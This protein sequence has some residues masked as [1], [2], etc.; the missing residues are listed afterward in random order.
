MII[1][2]YRDLLAGQ[3]IASDDGYNT[4]VALSFYYNRTQLP[5]GIRDN[6]WHFLSLTV[7]FPSITLL[8]DGVQYQ[9]TRG[10][11]RDNFQSTVN[12]NQVAGV[13]YTMPAQILTKSVSQINDIVARIGGSIRGSNFALFGEMRQLT[14]SNIVDDDTF[15]CL[16]SCNNIIGVDPNSSF[17]D[18]VTFY[19][20][21]TRTFDFTGPSDATGYT[22]L[23]QSLIYYTNGFLLPEESGER[24]IIT[25]RIN[26]ERGLGNEAELNL[27]GRSNQQDPL[28]DANGDL[29]AGINFL[30]DLREDVIEDQELE[31]LSPRSFIVDGD[32]DSVI[33]SLTVNLT[34]AQNGDLETIRLLDNPPSLVSVTNGNG[35]QLVA[36]SSSKVI[37]IESVDPLI[38]TANVFITTLVSLRY[39]NTAEE[40]LDIDRIIEFTVFDSL[41]TNNPRAQT[42]IS[43]LITDDVPLVD[44]NGP[45]GGVNNEIG[46]VESSPP[47]LLTSDMLITD[48]DSLELTQAIARIDRVFDEGNETLAFDPE[49]LATGLM[50]SPASCNGTEVT[51]TGPASQPS[52]QRILRT[53]QYVNLKQLTDLP[54]LRD[55]TVF[56][57]VNDGVNSSDPQV[58]ILIDFIPLN[59]RVIL[60]LD[61]PNQNYSITFVEAQASPI[62]C[63]SLVR[64][65]DSSIDTIESIVVSIRDVLPDGVVEN[66]ES[67]SLTSI[68]GLDNVI[69]IEINTALKRITFSQIAQVSQYIEAVR[70]IQYYNGED[71]PFL[72]N[73]FVD[74]LVIPG[75]GAPS[76][77]AICNITIDSVN[78]N[79]PQCPA[80]DPIEISEN[81]TNDY[82]IV[83]LEATDLDRGEDGA[84]SY[85][86]LNGNSA[87][88][89]VTT[90]GLVLLS[91]NFPLD[92][93]TAPQHS[94]TVEACDNGSPRQ[95]CQFNLTI[96]VTDVN[97][98]PPVF[99][100]PM[101]S[102]SIRENESA[103][104]PAIVDVSD[105]DEGINSQL[106]RVEIDNF[107]VRTGCIDQFVIRL[108]LGTIV[109]STISPGLDFE[110]VRECSFQVI[111]YDA[112]VPTLSGQ[113]AVTVVIIDQDDVPPVFTQDSYTFTV[114]EE[115]VAPTIVGTVHAVDSDSP[116]L[117]YSLS[118]VTNQ[119]EVN[120]TGVISI[121]F[122]S[123]RD[124][125]T[126]YIFTATVRDPPG[127]TDTA[128]V[129]V[130]VMPINNDA[131]QLDLN[132]TDPNSQDAL[133]PFIFIE[134]GEAVRILTDPN[135]TD[136]DELALTI[137][138]ITV[139]VA[140]SGNPSTE[141]LSILANQAT[142]PHTVVSTAPGRLVIQP[143]NINSFPDIRLL[144]QSV[145]YENTED[146]ISECQ[147]NMDAVCVFGPLSRTL[148]FT[149]SDGEFTSN[150]SNA[151]IEFQL[152]NDP[153]L[154]DLDGGTTGQNFNTQF[155]EQSDGVS[156]VNSI[157]YSITDEDSQNLISLVC[158]LTN[159]LDLDDD[160]LTLSGTLPAGLTATGTSHVLEI[161]GNSLI[162]DFQTAL[163]LVRYRSDSN[164][165]NTIERW[166]QV[167]VTDNEMLRSNI[168]M[169]TISFITSNDPPRLDLDTTSTDDGFSAIYIENGNPVS[170]SAS[171]DVTDVDNTNLQNLTVVIT[172][173]SG[174][175]DVLSLDQSLVSSNGLTYSYTY[176]ELIVTGTGSLLIYESIIE[177]IRYNNTE[178]EIADVMSRVVAFTIADAD[179]GVSDPVIAT[180][181]IQPVDDNSPI[182]VPTNFNFTILE[183]SSQS[184]LVGIVT[185]TDQDLPPG[186]ETPVFSI[187][188]STPFSDFII[189]SDP[190]NLFQG[191]ILLNGP[192]DYDMRAPAY[193]LE[194]LAQ[195]GS[196]NASASVTINVINLPDI[197]PMFQDSQCPSMFFT[198]ENEA[199]STPLTPESC[200]ATDPDSLDEIRYSIEGNVFNGI[201]VITIDQPTGRLTVFDDIDREM[202]GTQFPVVITATDS[203]QSTSQNVIIVIQGENE[204]DPQFSQLVYTMN[205][206]ENA[207]PSDEPIL[208]VL[209]TDADETPDFMFDPEF[210]TRITYS[211]INDSTI[212]QY[213]SINSTSGEIAQLL[214]IDYEDFQDFQFTV[215]ANDNDLSPIPREL[216]A[217]VVISVIN[218]NDER[219][220]FVNLTDRIFV[221][222]STEILEQFGTIMASDPDINA[223]LRFSFLPPV[224]PQFLLTSVRGVLS[225]I[226]SLDAEVSPREFEVTIQVQDIETDPRYSDASIAV[227]N[228]T[229]IVQDTNDEVPR[230]LS[231]QYSATVIENSPAGM[232]VLRVSAMDND[233]G[234]DPD[235]NSNGNNRLTYTFDG[236]DSPPANTFAIDDQTGDITIVEP[237]NR[238]DA[239]RY[240]F[241]VIVQDNPMTG[242]DVHTDR[243]TVTIEIGDVNEFPPIAD[244]D[245]YFS[246]ISEL[247]STGEEIL[248]F[249]NVA[250]N[251]SCEYTGCRWVLVVVHASTQEAGGCLWLFVR[252][253]G[254]QVGACACSCEYMGGRWVLVLVRA[255]TWE[256]GGCC[257]FDRNIER[258]QKSTMFN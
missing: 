155:I 186:Q 220:Q 72:V 35:V 47:T 210:V 203:T 44:L 13:N 149:V 22:A 87:L 19:N 178:D 78:D 133:T 126:Q 52:Y 257:F 64:V 183:N 193:N 4:Q 28:L 188:A 18:I 185:V 34:N 169:A 184:D 225:A 235:G 134:E 6:Q 122:T 24:R 62:R 54:N 42:I 115:N 158:N 57:T 1:Y 162:A 119:F 100:S 66:E 226:S 65:V 132:A 216:S 172:R 12:L 239:P 223:V 128:M 137:T 253:H 113:A 111:A 81:S 196:R 118:G 123:D 124:I 60:E 187:S 74:F 46:Y 215:V 221:S 58:N 41:R 145:T 175:Q 40:P 97:D 96:I 29:D 171:P 101:Y 181:G 179:G 139:Q 120:D 70:R 236:M 68:A 195:S 160:S 213:F 246:F 237:L 211:I 17:P 95:C 189:I 45:E 102:F 105:E 232:S 37:F 11:Y 204:H 206:E 238:E 91:G 116:E 49:E 243:A 151:F 99:A 143:Q 163:G 8:I 125:E 219:P 197:A 56:V 194:V 98:N 14:L 174:P 75:G 164:N 16:A 59:P 176:P 109:L 71:E 26:D 218:I 127:R 85:Q 217:Q 73:R 38:T 198:V 200:T 51:I 252:V 79:V 201:P 80:V 234:L 180:I 36:G 84:L 48:P 90:D 182:F 55:R 130:N 92:R 82:E 142:P 173:G 63:S 25:L 10:N 7:D 170:L 207:A 202:I 117:S 94:L 251:I 156:I 103:D 30:V 15:A 167:Y 61:A 256:A 3:S 233:Y 222:E 108:E 228:T 191:Q 93:E 227:A 248:T 146:E 229:I 148:L 77:T 157:S 9:P 209:A 106:A 5:N 245:L 31:I 254:R 141:V 2:Y 192:I 250:W 199:V 43:V 230:F 208:T 150:I 89:E 138:T 67:I 249:A 161:V 152:V 129:I 53:L 240:E 114:E 214:P 177:S 131:P 69:S 27:I 212:E 247:L 159:P 21:V 168:A 244:P 32:I 50:C 39:S 144:L 23:L 190:T 136:P 154:V 33:V 153:P 205:I 88:F 255:S 76:N 140:N 241:S 258:T 121:L 20:P 104:L 165:P 224:P 110:V 135:V 83:Q 231:M 86:L 147:D 242:G 166:V 107:S 112:G